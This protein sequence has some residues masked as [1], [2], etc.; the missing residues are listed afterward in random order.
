MKNRLRTAALVAFFAAGASACSHQGHLAYPSVEP[1][2]LNRVVLYRNGV[3]Y[4][5]RRGEVDGNVLRLKVRKDQINDMLKSLTVIDRTSGRALSVSM[6]LDPTT[7]AN[8]AL[9]TLAPGRGSLAGVL[10]KLRGVQ[11]ALAT[12]HGTVAGRIVM[13]ERIANEP[14][15]SQQKGRAL[16]QASGKSNDHKVTLMSGKQLRVVRL[17]K[18]K[19]ITIQDGDLA[20]QFHR[21]LDATAG[22]G[23]FQQVS[24]AIS[25]EGKGTHDVV[26]SYVVA[27]PMWKPTY[28][29]VIP[30]KGKG[31]ALLQAWAVVDNTSGED[32]SQVQ[33]SLTAGAPISFR[34]DLHTPRK[35]WRQDLSQHGSRKRA[36]V[37]VGETSYKSEDKDD[38]GH[39]PAKAMAA[40]GGKGRGY[41]KRKRKYRPLPAA[42]P[43]EEYGELRSALSKRGESR[44]P[45]PPA[46]VDMKL[47]RR[48]TRAQATA[49]T[50]SGQTRFD[51]EQRVTVPQGSS[52]MVAVVNEM[53]EGEET[54]LF[55]PG[56]AGQGYRNSPYRVIR[57]KNSTPFV[58]EPGPISIYSGGSF[59]GEGISETV[60]A[61]S[62]ATIPFAVEP[63]IMVRRT[64][65]SA[66]V[67]LKLIKIV[68]GVIYVQRFGQR[69]TE[70]EVKAQTMDK[71]FTVLVRHPRYGRNYQLKN[72][73]PGTEDLPDGYLIPVV[74][75]AG[76]K[77]HKVTVVEQ[78]PRQTTL[79]I[80]DRR[81]TK[82]LNTL[83]LSTDLKAV[84]KAKL[85]PLVRLRQDMGRIDTTI[86]GLKREKRQYR[87]RAN[88]TQENLYA[89]ERDKSLA[90]AKL[91]RDL[92]KRLDDFTKRADKVGLE[93]AKLNRERLQLKIKLEDALQKLTIQPG[94]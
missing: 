30:E 10:D 47:L 16:I 14:D 25:L 91:R 56:G 3:G 81:A 21:R 1:L 37:A 67:Q 42:K 43:T 46:A 48:S 4:F 65:K 28:R 77:S 41:K 39:E 45:A 13:V 54:F 79:S 53:V 58:L 62:S 19:N 69:K 82:L 32:W 83:M 68:R 50:A 85:E 7:W 63:G 93:I 70:W 8:A 34:Y 89:I 22:E 55:R 72:R 71:G 11:V 73:I 76:K 38:E 33:L 15:P 35:V 17:S 6:P 9:S 49:K 88:D 60:G 26:V 75:P 86:R 12:T 20:M 64:Y 94:K 78:S 57:F 44:A 52:T 66:P 40:S 90:A 84:D 24:V 23:M 80:W 2:N 92:Q 5:E 31:K 74:V 36:R 51:L 61:G 59:V 18:V 87:E 27:A 29:V